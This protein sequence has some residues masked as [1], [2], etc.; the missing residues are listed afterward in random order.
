VVAQTPN[1]QEGRQLGV[2]WALLLVGVTAAALG[3]YGGFRW[4]ATLDLGG[5]AGAGLV[6]LAVVTG[7]A[8]FFSPCSFPLLITMLARPTGDETENGQRHDGVRSALAVGF[9]A[10]AF[11][12]LT[13]AA[14]GLLGD[15]LADQ[16][17]FSTRGG[18]ILRGVVAGVLVLFGLVQLG[19]IEL[20]LAKLARLAGPLDRRRVA[21][22]TAHRR[23]GQVLYGFG[24]VLAGFG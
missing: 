20:P 22:A 19:M 8:V 11:L 18:R 2:R 3:G 5:Q 7:F 10:S 15:G 14:I 12:L 6:A 9:G 23:R 21:M 16:V 17:G 4:A 1:Q 24:F 13:G